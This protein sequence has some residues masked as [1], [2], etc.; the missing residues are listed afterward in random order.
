MQNGVKSLNVWPFYK[1]DDRLACMLQYYGINDRS[2]GK[3][4]QDLSNKKEVEK[5]LAS[6]YARLSVILP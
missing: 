4:P 6:E 2:R 3:L 5:F 1:S